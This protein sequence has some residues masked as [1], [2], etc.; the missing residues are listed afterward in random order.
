MFADQLELLRSGHF[1]DMPHH[2]MRRQRSMDYLI[3]WVLSGRGW[4]ETEGKRFEA[5]GGDLFCL[6]KDRPHEY[7]A[8]PRNPWDVVWVHFD[9]KLARGF[10]E[11]I[12]GFGGPRV[13]LG[14]DLE[15]RARWLELV[16]FHQARGPHF[17]T[18]AN[19]SLY[20]LLG[21]IVHRLQL[22]QTAKAAELP[23]D[24]HRVQT[25][26]GEHLGETITLA[27]LAKKAKLSPSHFT[28][29]FRKLFQV[30]PMQ[31][32]LQARAA[33]ACE[34]MTETSLPLKQIAAAVGYEDRYYFSRMFRKVM[35]VSPSGYRGRMK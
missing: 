17:Q 15:L 2:H 11:A 18:R 25:F 9:G 34:L 14:Q 21:L 35:G 1:F 19:T 22:R 16:V 12:R 27:M 24:V 29:V 28:R 26:I 32:V 33:K 7:G 3:F 13:K 20:A 8:Y 5:G 23:F 31:Y 6:L 4:V 10:A 30:S